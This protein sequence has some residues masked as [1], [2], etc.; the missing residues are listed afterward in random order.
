MLA[1]I[2]LNKVAYDWR[3]EHVVEFEREILAHQ[4]HGIEFF[5]FWGVHD[6]VL[7]LFNSG[8]ASRCN[9]RPLR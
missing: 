6:E 3:P 8:S 7:Q 4:K 9:P 2:G 1:K 5:A